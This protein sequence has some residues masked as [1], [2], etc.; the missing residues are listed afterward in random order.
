MGDR[1]RILVLRLGAM[2]D[3][4]FTTPALRGLKT[5]YPGCHITYVC[6]KKWTFLLKRNTDV[7]R[8]VGLHY[9]EPK[10]LGKVL[11][12]KFDL[13]VNFYELEDGAQL[14]QAVEADER[15]GHQWI[16]G[17]IQPDAESRL[18]LRNTETLKELYRSRVHYPELYC[19]IARV[20]ANDYR[21]VYQPPGLSRWLARRWLRKKKIGAGQY[22]VLH[23]H[24][25]GMPSKTWPAKHVH[26]VTQAMSDWKFVVIGYKP[27]RDM[28]KFLEDKPNVEVS[29][30][31][32][33]IQ[34]AIIDQAR[35]FIGIDSGPRQI[36]A[37]VGM[38]A[39]TLFGPR[40]PE[41]LPLFSGDRNLWVECP[42]YPCYD[43]PCRL[44]GQCMLRLDSRLIVDAAKEMLKS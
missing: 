30:A 14:C 10:A 42:E 8:V 2:G 23:T 29:L 5:K 11:N 37:A 40:P 44:G 16:N 28:T 7:D 3:I 33:E 36:A 18:L 39:L 35:L 21:Y 31:P 9:R 20:E 43:N 6:L 4:L 19:Q 24:S 26:E 1:K 41:H 15:L 13:I 25:R 12:E 34:A 22:I 32:I 27:D 17:K 38:S